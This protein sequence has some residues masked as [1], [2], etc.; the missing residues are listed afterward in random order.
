MDDCIFCKIAKGEIP[1]QKI[2]EDENFIAFLDINPINSG[3]TLVIPK[4]HFENLFVMPDKLISDYILLIKKLAPKIK[5]AMNARWV[6][7]LVFGEEIKH[8]HVH[9]IPRFDGDNFKYP[10]QGKYK[11]GEFEKITEKIVEKIKNLRMTLRRF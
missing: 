4:K 3:H 5:E 6:N 7:L 10:Q 1:T 9:I 2:Y 11:K 8:T